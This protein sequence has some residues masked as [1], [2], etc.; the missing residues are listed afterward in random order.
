M[1]EVGDAPQGRDVLV[2][3]DPQVARADAAL[4]ATALASVITSPAPPVAKAPRCTK[5]QSFANP[6]SLEYWHIGDTPIRFLNST[7]RNLSGEKSRASVSTGN[8]KPPLA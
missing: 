6:S 4:G 5:C 8:S 3:P 2:L 7:S 1:D